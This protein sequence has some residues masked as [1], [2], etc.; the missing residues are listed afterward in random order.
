MRRHL[1]LPLAGA[2]VLLV[3]SLASAQDAT[4]ADPDHY[5]VEVENDQVRI[6]RVSYGPGER[7]VMHEHPAHV[8]VILGDDQ[9][10]KTTSEDG[11]TQEVEGALGQVIWAEAGTHLPENPTD[12]RQEVVL[13]EIKSR[14]EGSP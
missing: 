14:H 1:S 9:L 10:W 11:E 3:T 13:I 12:R 6:V 8:A 7:S 4:V 2:A 5:K